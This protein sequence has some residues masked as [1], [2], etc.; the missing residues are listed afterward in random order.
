MNRCHLSICAIMASLTLWLFI[1][2][3]IVR[4]E[5]IES[6]SAYTL[7]EGNI[8]M[9]GLVPPVRKVGITPKLIDAATTIE[10]T[11]NGMQVLKYLGV[12]LDKA[13]TEFL[14]QHK[15]LLLPKSVTCFKGKVDFAGNGPM[16]WDEMLGM[17][18]EITGSS[19]EYERLPENAHLVTPAIVLHAF[20]KYMENVLEQLEKTVL[21]E[22][23]LH[24]VDEMRR[25]ALACKCATKG[26]LAER[27]EL[28]A[29]QFTVP[30]VM[31]ENSIA[32]FERLPY[33]DEKR[34]EPSDENDTL[35]NAKSILGKQQTNF[36]HD[37]YNR[38]E[39]ELELI[40]KGEELSL[41]PLFGQYSKDGSLK[42]DYTQ[43]TPR[44]HY[45]KSS[46]L[47]A[48]F[49]TMMYWGRNTYLFETAPGITDALLISYLMAHP[50]GN[51]RTIVDSWKKIMG[52]TGFFA[53]PAD[54]IGYDVWQKFVVS[55][56]NKPVF[57]PETAIDPE[58]IKKVNAQLGKLAPPRIL[59]DVVETE[60]VGE[61][62][63]SELLE[64][65]KGFRVFGQRFTFDA[66]ILGRLTAGRE[67]TSVRLPSAP[68]ALFIPTA[69]G[70]RQARM[71]SEEFYRETLKTS[72]DDLKLFRNLL[73]KVTAELG[74]VKDDE[75][76]LS[77]AAAWLRV[78]G[79]MTG[80]YGAGYPLYMRDPLFAIRQ[81]QE[82]LGSY[83][84]LKHDTL[85]Y[86]KQNYAECGDGGED[87]KVPPVP[88]GFVEPNL[89][90]WYELQRLVCYFESGLASETSF[91]AEREQYGTLGSFR[92]TIDFLTDLAEK[93]LSGRTITDDE[94]EKLRLVQLSYMAKP[95]GDVIFSRD[96][97][98][99]SALVADIHTD[100]DKGNILYQATGE[101]Y[102]ML[103]LVG[104]EKVARLT[105]GIT[106]N[107]YEFS[108]PL[109]KRLNDHEWQERV[110]HQHDQLPV[111]NTYYKSIIVGKNM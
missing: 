63:K 99:Y 40:Y 62:T 48:Y 36:S 70:D 71:L 47:R 72:D 96:E 54:D 77:A 18:D 27:F 19:K 9:F 8:P 33:S 60:N 89:P 25:R 16:A 67:K 86:A 31:L 109:G 3:P 102:V 69:L 76:F 50:D 4:V 26:N 87:M 6:P 34:V 79:T 46:A 97:D 80:T 43:Y 2:E 49:R 100:A 82:F 55:A 110:Y 59:S 53:G 32:S 88:K 61:M 78:L 17:F 111:K 30:A 83:T 45:R 24:F 58:F 81:I 42:S 84:E 90:F 98:Y 22:T 7:P 10:K 15:F 108:E 66:L 106:Y 41:S 21:R 64:K 65:T 14:N 39:K 105:I 94:Y 75:W 93:E 56:N 101:P 57:S 28:I 12:N 35:A 104:N 11:V 92:E 51:D 85:L 1:L 107:H 52:I 73:D 37:I 23:L 38:I 95:F 29:A 74:H 13:Q 91:A 103:V 68:T 20:H 5:A 44:S